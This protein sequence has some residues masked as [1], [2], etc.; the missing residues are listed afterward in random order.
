MSYIF[1]CSRNWDTIG[2]GLGATSTNPCRVKLWRQKLK[3]VIFKLIFIIRQHKK[4]EEEE[5]L[6]YNI[7]HRSTGD[8][9]GFWGKLRAGDESCSNGSSSNQRQGIGVLLGWFV[10]MFDCFFGS[11]FSYLLIVVNIFVVQFQLFVVW[12]FSVYLVAFFN[13]YFWVC[14]QL[15]ES[16]TELILP[17]CGFIWAS[18]ATASTG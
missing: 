10:H 16:C 14:K 7:Y 12:L 4:T 13:F 1:H 8:L 18:T 2:F 9:Q 11:F 3:N 5:K 17:R 6:I 15:N